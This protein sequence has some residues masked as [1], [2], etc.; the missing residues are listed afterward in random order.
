MTVATYNE[1]LNAFTVPNSLQTALNTEP[2][3]TTC[4]GDPLCERP[5]P[6]DCGYCMGD[7]VCLA[8][9]EAAPVPAIPDTGIPVFRADVFSQ[10]SGLFWLLILILILLASRDAR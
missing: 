1:S 2:P 3:M 5:A 9:C 6:P 10:S 4:M 8:G 7:P